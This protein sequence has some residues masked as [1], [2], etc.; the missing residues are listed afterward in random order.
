LINSENETNLTTT[1]QTSLSINCLYSIDITVDCSVYCYIIV[2]G[3]VSIGYKLVLTHRL[4]PHTL[5]L[6]V[7]RPGGSMQRLVKAC[8]PCFPL[9]SDVNV[10]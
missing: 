10:F 9:I 7:P 1:C 4:K 6:R 3:P 8:G 2:L 5:L